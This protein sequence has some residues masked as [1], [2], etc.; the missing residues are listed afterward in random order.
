MAPVFAFV[1]AAQS[2]TFRYRSAKLHI[3]TGLGFVLR[4]WV[5]APISR[6]KEIETMAGNAS[7]TVTIPHEEIVQIVA[8][9]LG[10]GIPTDAE[11]VFGGIQFDGDGKGGLEIGYAWDNSDCSPIEWASGKPSW[12]GDGK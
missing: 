10:N 1:D 12:L 6:E 2:C 5:R 4:F 3:L 11:I 7:G 8:K 9:A